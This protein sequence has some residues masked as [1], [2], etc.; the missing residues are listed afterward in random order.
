MPIP[1]GEILITVSEV[2][3][4]SSVSIRKAKK[5]VTYCH[6]LKLK[7]EGK[8]GE[9][10]ANGEIHMPDISE[11]TS[12]DMIVTFTSA[13]PGQDIFKQFIETEVKKHIIESIQVFV[14]ELKEV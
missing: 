3:G 5:I 8:S 11:D 13:N 9:I 2:L 10:S 4:D 6:E 14:Q 7:F 12:Y 1:E